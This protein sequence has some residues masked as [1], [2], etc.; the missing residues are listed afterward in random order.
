MKILFWNTNKNDRINSFLA[1]IIMDHSIDMIV[2]AEYVADEQEL[3]HMVR[4]NQQWIKAYTTI[5][6][7]RIHFYGSYSGVE[8]YVQDKY[9]S[10]QVVKEKY[11]I[12]GVHLPSDLHGDKSRERYKIAQIIM[13]D[14]HIAERDIGSSSTVIVGD[15]NDMPYSDSCSNADAFH[16][17]VSIDGKDASRTVMGRSYPK[18]YNPMWNLFGDFSYPPGTYYRSESSLYAPMWYMIDQ[19]IVGR[20]IFPFINKDELRIITACSCGELSNQNGHP[21]IK[22]SDHFPIMLAF[23]DSC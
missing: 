3:F 6:C 4:N 12:C 22:I 17:L 1:S 8:P 13:N 18:Y 10:I 15:L 9:Y 7:E 16:G 5:G 14:I 23:G 21:N 11:I 2:L 19:F 20:G